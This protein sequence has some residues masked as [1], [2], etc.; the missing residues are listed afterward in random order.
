MRPYSLV[1]NRRPV[2]ET[3]AVMVAG[4]VAVASACGGA[5]KRTTTIS[6]LRG[7][8]TAR[9]VKSRVVDRHSGLVGPPELAHCDPPLIAS[10]PHRDGFATIYVCQSEKQAQD[11]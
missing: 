11:A 10:R 1:R 7:E 3:L 6:R 2:F 8:L 4:A 9:G 5:S